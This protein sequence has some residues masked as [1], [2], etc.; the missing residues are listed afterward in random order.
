MHEELLPENGSSETRH[1]VERNRW[2]REIASKIEGEM[3][4]FIYASKDLEQVT[5]T[6]FEAM[7][8]AFMSL[9]KVTP[10]IK[11]EED[12]RPSYLINQSVMSEM[13]DLPDYDELHNVT[14]GDV[15][16]AGLASVSMEPKLEELF[17][18][19]KDEME[20]AEKLE[21]QMQQME[22]MQSDAS[23]LAEAMAGDGQGEG[24][25]EGELE[26]LEAQM[27]ELGEAISE[28]TEALQDALEG[29]QPL[30]A[31]GVENASD[32]ASEAVQALADAQSW[33]SEIGSL[34]VVDPKI[35]L[36]LAKKLS[37]PEFKK[38]SE[39]IGKLQSLAFSSLT[40][41]MHRPEELYEVT[42]GNDLP[43]VVPF[44]FMMLDDDHMQFD[45]FRK[46]VEHSLVQYE[47]KGTETKSKGPLILLEDC[48]SSMGGDRSI[49]AKAIALALLKIASMQHRGFTVIQFSDSSTQRVWNFDT[50]GSVVHVTSDNVDAHGLQGVITYAESAMTG[51][52]SFY[53]PLTMAYEQIV[54]ETEDPQDTGRSDI[55]F[56]TDDEC[57]LPTEFID[58]WLERS[59]EYN[60]ATFGIA[61]TDKV[62]GS[63][64][65]TQNEICQD[66]VVT[67]KD[68][69][70]PEKL[71]EV[72]GGLR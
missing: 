70:N 55:V 39:L 31:Q 65:G 8:D 32:D 37:S 57:S 64:Y 50:S 5:D 59:E 17:L 16:G 19:L 49:Y 51:G 25:L 14:M 46:Y 34:S 15:V 47:Y 9:Y 28:G 22:Q 61:I 58:T 33:G 13:L 1:V 71:M 21:Q 3:R 60:F 62:G 41:E 7:S 44:E 36:A 11:E 68:L 43:N 42:L 6:G 12:I 23:G 4:E 63:S 53:E 56:L 48:S 29:K 20:Q 38:M 52:T 26:R 40:E 27:A 45:F 54:A 2:D 69:D 67:L 72:F 30:I 66:R 24:D 10:D 18:N 35:R